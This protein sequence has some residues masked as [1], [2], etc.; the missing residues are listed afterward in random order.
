MP[1]ILVIEDERPMRTALVDG[2][3]A[4]GYLVTSAAD[5]E[6]GLEQAVQETPDLILLDV[7]MP[8]LDGFDV[9]R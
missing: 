2:L 3:Q 8:G 9:C 1:R 6:S 5:G 7:M 4:A